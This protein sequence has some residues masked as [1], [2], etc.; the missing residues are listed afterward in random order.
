MGFLESLQT[1]PSE[2]GDGAVA[3]RYKSDRLPSLVFISDLGLRFRPG[4]GSYIINDRQVRRIELRSAAPGDGYRM[5]PS[6]G[7]ILKIT[8]EQTGQMSLTPK[9]LRLV[10][11]TP[12]HIFLRGFQAMTMTP[13]GYIPF[14]HSDYGMTIIIDGMEIRGCIVHRF[15]TNVNY[16]YGLQKFLSEARLTGD[17]TPLFGRKTLAVERY[18]IEGLGK[19]Q[20]GQHGDAVYHPLYK[21]WDEFRRNPEVLREVTNYFSVGYGLALFL[22]FGTV[23]DIDFR[24]QISSVA[25]LFLSKAIKKEDSHSLSAYRSRSL[26]LK[27]HKEALGYT[28]ANILDRPF[29][30]LSI[31]GAMHQFEKRDSLYKMEY[32]DL[33]VIN[34][35]PSSPDFKARQREFDDM[36]ASGFFGKDETPATIVRKGRELHGKL[37]AYLEKRVLT[38][39]DID[40]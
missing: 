26:L 5:D 14:D 37:L 17:G 30:Y 36:I 19:L 39:G 28:V 12:D 18:A 35:V 20:A 11:E 25:Y 9:P 6:D 21:C 27:D 2:I 38:E 23:S 15:D 1:L 34:G 13:F 10:R 3:P 24:Q 33:T 16:G 4:D 8:D 7:Y 22:D 29:D 32:A 40:F 31:L